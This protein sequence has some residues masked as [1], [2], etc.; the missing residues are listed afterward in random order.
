LAATYLSL[1]YLLPDGKSLPDILKGIPSEINAASSEVNSSE[2]TFYGA[3]I[4]V[5]PPTKDVPVLSFDQIHLSATWVFDQSPALT[6]YVDLT[7][8]FQIVLSASEEGK[9]VGYQIARLTSS[10]EYTDSPKIKIRRVERTGRGHE[11]LSG[12][13]LHLF[14]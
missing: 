3:I 4:C 12:V 14:R 2:F 1:K 5:P 7:L 10:I 6:G 11:P 13:A 8:G 9:K